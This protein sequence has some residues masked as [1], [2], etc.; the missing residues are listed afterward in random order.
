MRTLRQ[1]LAEHDLMVLRAMGEWWELE[2]TGEEKGECID[3]LAKKLESLHIEDE[4]EFLP[5]DESGAIKE[6]IRAGGKLSVAIFSRK[7]GEVRQMGPAALE[8]EE[9][10][11]DPLSPA[12]ALWYRG[13]LFRGFDDGGD[14]VGEF[15]WLP[16]ELMPAAIES[17]IEEALPQT[18]DYTPVSQVE[19]VTEG[20]SQAVDD[21]TTICII[22][23]NDPIGL[24]DSETIF[25]Y[26][27]DRNPV[28][29]KMLLAIGQEIGV[30][31]QVDEA[32]KPA[33]GAVAW[34][35]QPREGQLRLLAEGWSGSSWNDLRQTP[36]LIFEG[37]GWQNDPILPRTAL[38][39][40]LPQSTDWYE[41]AD[42]AATVKSSAPDF[43]R[44]D[45]NYDTWYIRD[46]Q[47]GEYLKGFEN[48]EGVE[49]R[50]LAFLIQAPLHWLGMVD[51]ADEGRYR[52]R[53]RMVDWLADE[54]LPDDEAT[55]P[56]ILSATGAI[57]VPYNANRFHRFQ[58][59]RIAEATVVEPVTGKG[60][61]PPFTYQI[62][63]QSLHRARAQGIMPERAL[64]FLADV[65][66]RAIPA[67]IKRA[68]ERW[69]NS[70]TEGRITEMTVL[71]VSSPEILD[72]LR[73]NP[74][75]NPY[76][77]ESLGDLAM[78]VVDEVQLRANAVQL[79]LLLD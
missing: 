73:R 59:G 39:D 53:E 16:K 8:R 52:I 10:W 57:T 48:W 64:A 3:R 76:L 78:M 25:P 4:L 15:F 13:F 2:L 43:Q 66:G 51:L 74:K 31:R 67:G 46:E 34:L 12:E 38:L 37:E 58:L 19:E 42:V 33:K 47:S 36:G 6:L 45:G 55:A 79:G 56:P 35:Q 5:A 21:L 54:P 24:D 27:L 9:P 62:S 7:Y 32:I 23:Q 18:E 75:T 71:R 1:F 20:S 60:I 72:I 41:I 69:G 17:Y 49:G 40:A 28:R 44:L 65:T 77:G 30:L 68:I 29:L 22:A 26:L 61:V 11:F 14:G 50:L 63:P 70:G